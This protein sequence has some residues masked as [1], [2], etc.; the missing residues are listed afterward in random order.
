M[1]LINLNSIPKFSEKSIQKIPVYVFGNCNQVTC[2]DYSP[3]LLEKIKKF[4]KNITNSSL[5]K[6]V[7]EHDARVLKAE[8]LDWVY[9]LNQLEEEFLGSDAFCQNPSFSVEQII[10]L[11][12]LFSRLCNAAPGQ[13]RQ[14]EISWSNENIDDFTECTALSDL[15]GWVHL[16][17]GGNGVDPS[18]KGTEWFAS[19]SLPSAKS[20]EITVKASWLHNRLR[21]Y[22]NHPETIMTPEGSFR[23][24]KINPDLAYE[25]GRIYSVKLSSD[26]PQKNKKAENSVI[27]LNKLFQKYFHFFPPA[28]LVMS[29]LQVTLDVIGN[30][31]MH[32]I[33]KASRIWFEVVRIHISHEANKRTGK[34]LASAILLANGYLP[35][36]IDKDSSAEYVKI[37][38][39]GFEKEDG[40]ALFTD[41]IARKILET[42]A[43]MTKAIL[44]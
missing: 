7:P 35:P 13:P 42:Q 12:G 11:N 16:H 3:E 40:I 27:S 44:S 21:Q 41:F 34:A 43:R 9:G 23:E 5:E 8:E 39:E 18:P 4:S 20:Q 37:M 28:A 29:E 17:L 14:K 33:E 25:W 38:R 24:Q 26:K 2:N 10:R 36:I 30:K 32:P 22:V 31:A 6:L 19:L 1:S 15:Q